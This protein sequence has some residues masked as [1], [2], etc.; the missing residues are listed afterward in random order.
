M[1]WWWISLSAFIVLVG[2]LGF[3]AG[4]KFGADESAFWKEQYERELYFG[5][6]RD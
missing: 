3:W 6:H 4:Y 2:I 5:Q 1:I